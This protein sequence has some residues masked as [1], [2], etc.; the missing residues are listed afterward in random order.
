MT[1]KNNVLKQILT[2]FHQKSSR[3]VP[4]QTLP[5]RSILLLIQTTQALE[6]SGRAVI[7]S[8]VQRQ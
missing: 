5:F 8:Q 3:G 2:Y 1:S 7:R 6:K 4:C